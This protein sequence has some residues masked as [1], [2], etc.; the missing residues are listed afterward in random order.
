MNFAWYPC[1]WLLVA[2]EPS[3]VNVSVGRLEVFRSSRAWWVS[4]MVTRAPD[5][6]KLI[7]R[8]GSR[9]GLFVETVPNTLACS[10]CF[11]DADGF[12]FTIR[13]RRLW[14]ARC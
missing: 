5:Q 1:R 12:D 9:G 11:K 14:G 13:E 4:W 3:R 2:V 7:L 8:G 10:V 6:R